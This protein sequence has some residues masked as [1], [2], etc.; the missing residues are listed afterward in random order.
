MPVLSWLSPLWKAPLPLKIK[1]FVW[2]LLRDCLPSG[3]EVL[4]RHGPDN[5]ICPLCHVPETGSH[6]LFSCVVAQAL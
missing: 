3:T 6:I 5:G 2:Q 1:I 4:K